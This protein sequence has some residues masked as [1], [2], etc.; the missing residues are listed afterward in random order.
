[1]GEK[2]RE[3]KGGGGQL[4]TAEAQGMQG[5]K[6]RK[7]RDKGGAQ[8]RERARRQ[9]ES[10]KAQGTQGRKQLKEGITATETWKETGGGGRQKCTK[11]TGSPGGAKEKHNGNRNRAE[12][13]SAPVMPARPTW[14][15]STA[16]QPPSAWTSERPAANPAPARYGKAAIQI[17][18]C[19]PSS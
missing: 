11:G 15:Q 8:K 18:V 5:R 19:A 17:D 1:M 4:Q 14:P 3:R 6:Q 2:K 10:A 16:H 9:P 12:H 7:N 13:Q